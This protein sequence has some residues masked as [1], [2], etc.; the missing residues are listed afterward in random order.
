MAGRPRIVLMDE[1]FVAL[2][3]LTRDAIGD[4]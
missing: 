3:P 2:D 4:D 1:P